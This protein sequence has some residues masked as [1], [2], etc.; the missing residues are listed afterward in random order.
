ML[1][2][3]NFDLACIELNE[4]LKQKFPDETFSKEMIGLFVVMAKRYK[5]EWDGKTFVDC[6]VEVEDKPSP[7][8]K[9]S[10]EIKKKVC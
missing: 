10:P 9:S 5:K 7:E 2:W 4:K 1:D 6:P 3:V 8:I